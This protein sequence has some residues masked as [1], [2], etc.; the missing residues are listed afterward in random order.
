MFDTH[1]HPSR[2]CS[3]HLDEVNVD[4]NHRS[5]L[6]IPLLKAKFN[7]IRQLFCR[8][9]V[10]MEP[11][12][13]SDAELHVREFLHSAALAKQSG[14]NAHLERAI[15]YGRIILVL[16]PSVSPLRAFVFYILAKLCEK[17]YHQNF[18][19]T[20]LETAIECSQ[21][22]VDLT[23][24]GNPDRA[25]AAFNNPDRAVYLNDLSFYLSTRYARQGKP[26]DL[27]QA[28]KYN[29][30][31]IDLTPIDN[32]TRANQLINLSNYL[33]TRYESE[34]R[35]EDLNQAIK[36]TQEAVDLTSTSDLER[37]ERARCINNLSTHLGTRYIREKKPE[38][39]AQAIEY[40]QEVVGM[41]PA[42]NPNRA[43]RLN[44]FSINLTNRYES[45]GRLEDLA[46]AIKH[47]QEAV[48]LTSTSNP[49]RA[50]FL[51]TLSNNLNTRY[52]REKRLED[53]DQAI[54]CDQEVVDLTSAS[55]PKR[56]AFLN[57]L[58]YHLSTRR[59]L[60][61]L[62]QAI[63]HRQNATNCLNSPPS[64]RISGCRGAIYLLTQVQRWQE[65]R[66]LLGQGLEIL[67]LLISNLSSKLDQE[68]MIKSIS[69]LAA[70]GCAVSLECSDDGIEA[71]RVLE[72]TRGTINRLATNS[73]NEGSM[74]YRS[75]PHP[76]EQF[77]DLRSLNNAPSEDRE[78]L[79]ETTL[80]REPVTA[81]LRNLAAHVPSDIGFESFLDLPSK[82][83]LLENSFDQVTVFLN[84]TWFRTDAILIHS[85]KRIQILPLDKSIF[86]HSNDYYAGLSG[87]FGCNEHQNWR[88]SNEDMREFLIWLWDHIVDPILH[89]FGFGPSEI[90]SRSNLPD[91]QVKTSCTT[92]DRKPDRSKGLDPET[93]TTYLEFMRR[94]PNI[95]STV[96]SDK[97]SETGSRATIRSGVANFP[98]IHW[99]GVGHTGCFPFHAAGYGSQD[100]PRNTMS[101]VISSYASTLTAQAHAKQRPVA[102]E[103]SSS[104]LLLVAMPKTPGLPDLPG[105]EE[106]TKTIHDTLQG[107][108]KVDLHELQPIDV[109]L[110]DLPLYNFVHFACHGDADP[111]SPFRSGLLL[112]GSEPEK[113]FHENTRNSMLT[114]ETISSIDTQRS[115][116]AFLSACC[117]AENAYSALMDEGIHLA[118]GFQS[119]GY[120]HVIA[121]LWEAN[122]ALSVAVAAKFYSIVFAE[123]EIVGHDKIAYAL[124][125]A[126][127]AAQQM[128]EDPLSWATTIHFG[129]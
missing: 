14:E 117:T 9:S 25:L 118:S 100:P 71:I 49:E 127:L 3:V 79:R 60:E 77:E 73:T 10:P 68:N 58:G 93:L 87:R 89:A 24:A 115:V 106:E 19:I 42:E 80:S 91:S 50:E 104:A 107:L 4:A 61:D 27:A 69:G 105:V 39:I 18:V 67:P 8:I 108:V 26:E 11:I 120:P 97:P 12:N 112:C 7:R 129:P 34:Q 56:A 74:L 110:K 33:S 16:L 45:E 28:I 55:N 23:P 37:I 36:Y 113:S 90:L 121:S 122:D 78:D 84:T 29:Q 114:V 43:S 64:E 126:V 123:S 95:A 103:P 125:D 46:Q 128:C 20:N 17:M 62:T 116:L 94:Q 99:I 96:S 98:R 92:Q 86:E 32:P 40:G 119:A 101:C 47:S 102:L 48:D 44:N 72:L 124:H 41:T 1:N 31:A 57:R 63:E 82:V 76:A 66:A 52:K 13:E 35:L 88:R 85:N 75:D 59:R 5:F 70:I 109:I 2:L 53:L 81:T 21:E 111:Q 54:K 30:E 65:A 38:D 6:L 22:A 15:F 51:Y 83:E